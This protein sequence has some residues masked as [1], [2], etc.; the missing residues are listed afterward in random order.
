MS[1]EAL[2]QEV[3]EVVSIILRTKSSELDIESS[4]ETVSNWDSINHI[5][6]ILALEEEFDIDIDD[7]DIS[8]LFNIKNIVSL[9]E[10]KKHQ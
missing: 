2:I 3:C 7:E 9:I 10:D 8:T 6:L 4:S 5:N 1:N